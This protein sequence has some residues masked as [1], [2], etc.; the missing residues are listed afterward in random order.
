M[1]DTRLVRHAD[2]SLERVFSVIAANGYVLDG[3]ISRRSYCDTNHGQW[4]FVKRG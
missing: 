3:Q 2:E 1:Y 4:F